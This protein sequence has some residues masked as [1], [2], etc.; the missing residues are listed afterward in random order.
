MCL[1]TWS[2]ISP[3]SIRLCIEGPAAQLSCEDLTAARG[4]IAAP[5]ALVRGESL[6]RGSSTQP[7]RNHKSGNSLIGA[8]DRSE[9]VC[10]Q[11]KTAARIEGLVYQLTSYGQV[12]ELAWPC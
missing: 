7:E 1:R 10:A 8:S 11:T 5:C 4:D 2:S 3:R 9:C 12:F 6:A